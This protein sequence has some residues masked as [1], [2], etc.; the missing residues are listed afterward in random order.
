MHVHAVKAGRQTT[1]RDD[2]LDRASRALAKLH[3]CDLLARGILELGV[4]YHNVAGCFLGS[5]KRC[6]H[7]EG[8]DGDGDGD[9]D[10]N[11]RVL[12]HADNLVSRRDLRKDGSG[13]SSQVAE[14]PA[15]VRVH[16]VGT[17]HPP[18]AKTGVTADAIAGGCPAI[19]RPATTPNSAH[20][21]PST[22]FLVSDVSLTDPDVPALVGHR[23]VTH[24]QL[25]T[26][27][28]RHGHPRGVAFDAGIAALSAGRDVALLT[29]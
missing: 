23:Q 14:A 7:A 12:N 24:A 3:D 15:C 25:V 22:S 8:T 20:A 27:A 1:A 4:D 6:S 21:A 5:D 26:L 9:G 28:R 2:D 18:T 11:A 29:A 17:G 19:R 10:P 13:H 16:A